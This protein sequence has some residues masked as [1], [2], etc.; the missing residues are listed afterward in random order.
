MITAT[1]LWRC[2]QM[3]T[4]MND[5]KLPTI[6]GALEFRR[7]QYGWTNGKFAKKIGMSRSHFSEVMNGKRRLP[8]NARIKAYKL[9]VSAEVLLQNQ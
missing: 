6:I 1:D 8:L 5:I 9:G 3:E 2:L 4:R 7:E